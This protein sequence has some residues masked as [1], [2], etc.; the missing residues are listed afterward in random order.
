MPKANYAS[1][2]YSS[3][4]LYLV[5]DPAASLCSDRTTCPEDGNPTARSA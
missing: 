3:E 1:A 2:I 4:E 5:D